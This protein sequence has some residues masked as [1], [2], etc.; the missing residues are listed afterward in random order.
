MKFKEFTSLQVIELLPKHISLTYVD[1]NDNLD[2]RFDELQT[3]LSQGS[4]EHINCLVD[5]WYWEQIEDNKRLIFSELKTSLIDKYDI[6]KK[7][8]KKLVKKFKE[9]ITNAIYDNWNDDTLECL[10]NNTSDMIMHYETGYEMKS[11]S[12]KWTDKEVKAER[13]KIKK[14]LAIPKSYTKPNDAI[15][16]MIR[17]ATYGGSLLIYFNIKNSF[18]DF[19]RELEVAKTIVFKNYMFGI[20]DYF[21]GSGDVMSESISKYPAT[22]ELV[23]EN[24]FFEQSI[25]YNWTYSIAGMCRDWADNTDVKFKQ[26]ESKNKVELSAQASRQIQEEEYN[27]TFKRGACT[28]MDMDIKRHRNV[29]YIN[30]YPCGNKCT[31]CGT[32]WID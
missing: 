5:E 23:R 3:C 12:W 1:R 22:F 7:K 9:E 28:H 29:T 17:Q 8:A 6:K 31:D 32:F 11:E 16:M 13:I 4:F 24:I 25:K 26:E 27:K 2:N 20:V 18:I 19:V 10:L 30:N 14:H 15:E 21:N